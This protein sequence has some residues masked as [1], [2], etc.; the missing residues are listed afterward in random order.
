MPELQTLGLVDL[1]MH[2]SL[3][4]LASAASTASALFHDVQFWT[5]AYGYCKPVRSLIARKP[6]TL[7]PRCA[8]A[9]SDRSPD[10]RLQR[11]CS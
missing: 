5:D 9:P 6:R 8:H 7:T 4:A 11:V 3:L 1:V 2:K 10:T